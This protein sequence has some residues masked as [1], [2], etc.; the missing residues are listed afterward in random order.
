VGTLR[1]TLTVNGTPAVAVS[2]IVTCDSAA[3]TLTAS[4]EPGLTSVV[5]AYTNSGNWVRITNPGVG[6]ITIKAFMPAPGWTLGPTGTA[7]AMCAAGK[8]LSSGSSCLVLEA[9]TGVQGPDT[10][11]SGIQRITSSAS[12]LTWTSSP[13]STKGIVFLNVSPAT[14]TPGV[15]T[16]L[17]YQVANQAP[18]PAKN[19]YYTVVPKAPGLTVNSVTG[20]N[21]IA[22]LPANGTCTVNV[23][24]TSTSPV[25]AA[26]VNGLWVRVDGYYDSIVSGAPVAASLVPRV[27]LNLLDA[28]VTSASPAM[29]V[30]A[31]ASLDTTVGTP[32]ETVF[33]VKNTGF[34]TLPVPSATL[35]GST[36]MFTVATNSCGAPLAPGAS[37]NIA[38]RYAAT[39]VGSHYDTLTVA[40]GSLTS[41]N[42]ISARA[43]PLGV[44]PWG[45][46]SD[47]GVSMGYWPI[48][49]DLDP[50]GRV[51]CGHLTYAG[52]YGTFYFDE[53]FIAT[54]PRVAQSTNPLFRVNQDFAA[55]SFYTPVYAEARPEAFAVG[56]DGTKYLYTK[57]T[58]SVSFGGARFSQAGLLTLKSNGGVRETSVGNLYYYPNADT[59]VQSNWQHPAIDTV[60]NVAFLAG[61]NRTAA[62]TD[63]AYR[64]DD[65]N[66]LYMVSLT[67]GATIRSWNIAALTGNRME[68][69]VMYDYGTGELIIPENGN[70]SVLL[71]YNPS[72]EQWKRT[73][74]PASLAIFGVGFNVR[75]HTSFAWKGKIYFLSP[76]GNAKVFNGDPYNNPVSKLSVLDLDATTPTVT[77]LS[78]INPGAGS[79]LSFSNHGGNAL[80][81]T[82]HK[83]RLALP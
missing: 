48:P 25:T 17:S 44:S 82:G 42:A 57:R 54:E 36:T 66:A 79:T 33:V 21:S 75:N 37:C 19:L 24:V 41:A 3:P 6:P 60:R 2:G 50:Q 63:A 73:V 20:C 58:G 59:C 38:V 78:S 81:V 74:I 1:S 30:T 69:Q 56:A 5:G 40:S 35:S 12:D 62:G 52:L 67:T 7:A 4:Y 14:V 45:A 13:I 61:C 49:W 15:P 76:A 26:V 8:V 64:E 43:L 23:S 53:P 22:A 68:Q 65:A 34:T 71:R 39:V 55:Y 31:G 9:L 47:C 29:S 16:V 32:T 11:V 70:L 72:T 10:T 27:K 18:F 46:I 80:Y 83:I 28:S 51:Q 77:L